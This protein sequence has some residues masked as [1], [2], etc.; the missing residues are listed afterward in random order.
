[1]DN[2]IASIHTPTPC[3]IPDRYK[4]LMLPHILHDFHESYYKYLP[5]FDGEYGNITTEIHIYIFESFLDL[6]EV[7]EDDVSIRIFAL[8]LQGKA[9]EWFK[10]LPVASNFDFHQFVK[11]FLDKCMI[12]RNPFLIL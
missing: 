5:R 10:N 7:D 11:I 8:S 2:P 12:K 1:M 6:F 4:P 9:K 3:K